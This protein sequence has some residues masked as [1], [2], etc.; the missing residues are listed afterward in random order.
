[1]VVQAH[2]VAGKA[3]RHSLQRHLTCLPMLGVLV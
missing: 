3:H 2:R 1:V